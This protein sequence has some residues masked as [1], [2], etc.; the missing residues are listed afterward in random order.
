M[1]LLRAVRAEVSLRWDVCRLKGF[2]MTR[3]SPR[4]RCSLSIAVVLASAAVSFLGAPHR[5][6]STLQTAPCSDG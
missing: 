4:R 2:P 5:L 1:R 6:L 3:L